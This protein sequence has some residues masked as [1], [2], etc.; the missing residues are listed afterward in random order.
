MIRWIDCYM[1]IASVSKIIVISEPPSEMLFT[2][3]AS[4]LQLCD[5]LSNIDDF[6]DIDSPEILLQFIEFGNI[7]YKH[8][9]SGHVYIFRQKQL[10]TPIQPNNNTCAIYSIDEYHFVGIHLDGTYIVYRI[11]DANKSIELVS[12][13]IEFH[14]QVSSII[15]TFRTIRGMLYAQI[16]SE[17]D[18]AFELLAKAMQNIVRK[19]LARR[20][21]L[22]Y[23]SS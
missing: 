22:N 6:R 4:S 19:V 20:L 18:N 5:N 12:E 7:C 17:H 3:D 14:N 15:D 2:P 9:D 13:P 23:D 8:K 10:Y 16:P 1:R 11:N 21:L